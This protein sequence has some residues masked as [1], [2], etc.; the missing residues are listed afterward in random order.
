[1]VIPP[2]THTQTY[3]P[4]RTTNI[5]QYTNVLAS[6]PK[7]TGSNKVESGQSTSDGYAYLPFRLRMCPTVSACLL[8]GYAWFLPTTIFLHG[9]ELGLLHL[10]ELYFGFFLRYCR[11][12]L[13]C[14]IEALAVLPPLEHVAI[15]DPLPLI[16]IYRG[17]EGRLTLLVFS[18]VQRT[19]MGFPCWR[20]FESCPTHALFF[21]GLRQ[22]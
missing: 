7:R 16:S 9:S 4:K 11:M 12:T 1:M 5:L 10:K 20:V 14:P 13:L 8:I 18:V 15:Y 2:H 21:S 3:L 17:R 19:S 6:A 22:L